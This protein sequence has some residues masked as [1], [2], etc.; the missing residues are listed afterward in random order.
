MG[1]SPYR[2][3]GIGNLPKPLLTLIST[4]RYRGIRDLSKTLCALLNALE[5]LDRKNREAGGA[6][7]TAYTK[8]MVPIRSLLFQHAD[9]KANGVR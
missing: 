2:Y 4:A 5:T 6:G 7:G 3:L 8:W 1:I 9:C